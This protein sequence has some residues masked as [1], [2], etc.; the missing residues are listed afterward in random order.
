VAASDAVPARGR[1]WP[2]ACVCLRG[3]PTGAGPPE[4]AFSLPEAAGAVAEGPL[5]GLVAA[6]LGK[7]LDARVP[8]L[9][10]GG[11]LLKALNVLM[12]KILDFSD[13][14]ARP[15]PSPVRGCRPYPMLP[16]SSGRAPGGSG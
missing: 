13:R 8:A 9:P 4:Q 7:L 11:Q 16:S 1:R 12:L 6:L 14:R 5:R 10:D 15:N 3:F 2:R